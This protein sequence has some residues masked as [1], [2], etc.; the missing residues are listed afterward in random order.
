MGPFMATVMGPFMATVM[1]PFMATVMGPFMATV[2]GPCMA[3]YARTKFCFV[4][5]SKQPVS[6]LLLRLQRAKIYKIAP[7]FAGLL[8]KTHTLYFLCPIRRKGPP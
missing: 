1:G 3:S 2:M 7:L 5:I 6:L 4:V 8:R